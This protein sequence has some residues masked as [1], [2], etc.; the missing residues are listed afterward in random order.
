M[1]GDRT[2]GLAVLYA[3]KDE[4]PLFSSSCCFPGVITPKRVRIQS[5][6]RVRAIPAERAVDKD[7]RPQHDE[8]LSELV[9]NEIYDN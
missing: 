7:Q 1:F 3:K 6:V 2:S 4:S 5:D 9:K 8:S